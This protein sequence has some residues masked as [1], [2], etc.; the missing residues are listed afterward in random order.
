MLQNALQNALK[1]T[2]AHPEFKKKNFS[3][4]NAQ[5]PFF[6]C[7]LPKKRIEISETKYE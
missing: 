6:T 5:D 2:Y 1:C 7:S 3:G 4:V